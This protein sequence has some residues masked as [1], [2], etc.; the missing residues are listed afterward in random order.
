MSVNSSI[1][2]TKRWRA[3]VGAG[4][5]LLLGPAAAGCGVG[6]GA[7][8]SWTYLNA[9]GI[10]LA[11][12]KGWREMSGARLPHG[13]LGEAVLVQHGD[14]V[15]RVEVL[16]GADKRRP[17]GVKVKNSAE[18]K[19]GGKPAAQVSYVYRPKPDGPRLRV[20]DVTA[21]TAHGTPVLI[22]ISGIPGEVTQDTMNRIAD[23]IQV[24]TIG[25]GN[26]LK[27]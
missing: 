25:K 21:H 22:R 24:G 2:T 18:F 13:M 11:H 17:K 20:M 1:G 26:I 27:T 12:P 16:T 9:H 5:V 4:V 3:L 23:S 19:L 10:A 14:T 7:P 8:D 15:G 6:H